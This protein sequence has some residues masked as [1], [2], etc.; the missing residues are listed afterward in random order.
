MLPQSTDEGTYY[1]GRLKAKT[2]SNTDGLKIRFRACETQRKYDTVRQTG[3]RQ[4]G[5]QRWTN[6]GAE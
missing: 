4:T 1:R 5:M 2:D 6:S 3:M